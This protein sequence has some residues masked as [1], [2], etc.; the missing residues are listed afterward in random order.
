MVSPLKFP[1]HT[2][3]VQN[4]IGQYTRKNYS[5][6]LQI[7]RLLTRQAFYAT[8]RST[9]TLFCSLQ[10][11]ASDKMELSEF[12]EFFVKGARLL[13]GAGGPD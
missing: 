11:C 12:L 9:A 8:N 5:K 4:M 13:L 10:D 1:A 7:I 3:S 6:R 2:S